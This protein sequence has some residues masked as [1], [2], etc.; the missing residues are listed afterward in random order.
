MTYCKCLLIGHIAKLVHNRRNNASTWCILKTTVVMYRIM[1][2][3]KPWLPLLTVPIIWGVLDGQD[4][5]LNLIWLLISCNLVVIHTI[6]MWPNTKLQPLIYVPLM[7]WLNCP[8]WHCQLHQGY[9][10]TTLVEHP[11]VE[12]GGRRCYYQQVPSLLLLRLAS[13][14][15]YCLLLWPLAFQLIL[16]AL[17]PHARRW[18]FSEKWSLQLQK[19]SD[20]CVQSANQKKNSYPNYV[21]LIKRHTP[22]EIWAYQSA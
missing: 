7:G 18:A 21:F 16:S 19:R 13:W 8:V 12:E 9:A 10:S 17:Q 6:L 3:H 15:V 1:S 11:E 22:Y 2:M 4:L 5:S 14:R 20:S